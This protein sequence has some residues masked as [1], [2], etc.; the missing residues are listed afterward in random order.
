M[1]RARWSL[2]QYRPTGLSDGVIG[3]VLR[4]GRP[5]NVSRRRMRHCSVNPPLEIRSLPAECLPGS[6]CFGVHG[7]R[8]IW[9]AFRQGGQLGDVVG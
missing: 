5:G 8:E 9:P 3:V 7:L 4:F 6:V 1:R 2:T